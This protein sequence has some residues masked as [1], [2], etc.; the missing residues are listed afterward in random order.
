MKFYSFMNPGRIVKKSVQSISP[1]LLFFL[2]FERKKLLDELVTFTENFSWQ[3]N[4]IF[5]KQQSGTSLQYQGQAII[6]LI[7]K[8]TR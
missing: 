3:E 6:K 7:E 8:R 4:S 5:L 2:L 1:L